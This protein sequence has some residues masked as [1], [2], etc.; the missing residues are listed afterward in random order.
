MPLLNGGLR[1]P[2]T[3]YG[4][5]Q[6]LAPRIVALFPRHRVYFEPFCGGA[7]VLFAKARAERET[8]N[9][10]DR[11]VVR[12]WRALRDRP[13]EL[14]R[15]VALTPYSRSEWEECRATPG[16]DDD[17]EAARRFLCWI[18]QSFSREGTG[19]SPPSVLFDRRGRWQSGVWQNLPEKLAAAA[20][21]L[22]GVALECGDALELIPRYD[23]PDALIYCDP[24]YAGPGRAAPDKGYRFDAA[25][26]D[27][28]PRL[29]EVL[30][31]VRHA[32]VVL[33]GYP[34]PELEALG[35]PSIAMPRRRSVSARSGG[36]LPWTP[37]RLWLSP[38]LIP[39]ATLFSCL[40]EGVEP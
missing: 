30:R 40:E 26:Q 13:D 27:L 17:V 23:Q 34:C 19:W 18:D 28:W 14:A 10:L 6:Q 1:T 8:L 20:T 39:E 24:P 3:Y 12:F 21:R 36:T 38:G 31:G 33:S 5:K 9:D 29:V 25:E 11:Q 16:A 2:L 35:W 37:E 15:A 4:G 22:S 32:S 7:A